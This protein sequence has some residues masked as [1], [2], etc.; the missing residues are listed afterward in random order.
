MRIDIN[1]RDRVEDARSWDSINPDTSLDRDVWIPLVGLGTRQ[2]N[3]TS[4]TKQCARHLLQGTRVVTAKGYS[5]QKEELTGVLLTTMWKKASSTLS[6]IPV[7]RETLTTKRSQ[8]EHLGGH[9]ARRP[10]Q[11]HHLFFDPDGCEDCEK[12][13]RRRS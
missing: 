1:D 7:K 5:H 6:R 3:D 8:S 10:S 9:S 4:H 11:D 12:S 13:T 2:Y